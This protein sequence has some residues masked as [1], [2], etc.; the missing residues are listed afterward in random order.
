[1]QVFAD[2]GRRRYLQQTDA[3]ANR[4]EASLQPW[5]KK[6]EDA[7]NGFS[8]RAPVSLALFIAPSPKFVVPR[9]NLGFD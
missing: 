2:P 5:G 6:P 8:A 3:S 9:R 7:I 1:V 4:N